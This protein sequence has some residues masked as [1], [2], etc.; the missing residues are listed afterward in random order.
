ME[1]IV[2][3]IP[4][5]IS[6]TFGIMENDFVGADCSPRE[7]QIYTDLFK[8]FCDVFSWSYKEMLGIDPKNIRGLLLRLF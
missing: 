1:T 3:T 8:E 4:S 6:R 2:E 7:I 5:N